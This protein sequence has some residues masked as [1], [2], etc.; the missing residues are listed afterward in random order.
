[1]SRQL[2]WLRSDLRIH[3]NT[4]LAAAAAKGPVVAV[5]LRSVAQWQAHGHGINKIDFWARGVTALKEA[6]DGLNI[7][8]LHRDI[9]SFDDAPA[10]LLEIARQHRIEQLHFNIE[11]PL[12]ER[13]RDQAVMEASSRQELTRTDIMMRWPLPPGRC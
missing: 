7:P 12:N 9:A 4:A 13:R 6:L 8:L 5:F 2:V 3:D 1:M 11:Y 10:T